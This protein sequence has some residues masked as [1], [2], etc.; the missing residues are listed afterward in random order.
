MKFLAAA[1]LTIMFVAALVA[2][3]SAG[4]PYWDEGARTD[5]R[6]AARIE[7][8]R[9]ERTD[10]KRSLRRLHARER[11]LRRGIARH[12][13]LL[14]FIKP[15]S[16]FVEWLYPLRLCESTNNY[17]AVSSSGTYRGAY[18][19]SMSTWADAYGYT[20]PIDAPWF[21]QDARTSEVRRARGTSPWPTCG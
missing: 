8:L 16:A 21:V 18:Q 4:Y 1:L 9:D 12:T 5:E 6:Q 19:F 14:H 17:L 13:R 10:R 15:T 20:D 11:S 7:H 2:P 3:A